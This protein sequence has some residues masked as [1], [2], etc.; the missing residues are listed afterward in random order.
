MDAWICRALQVLVRVCAS[1]SVD[2]CE[3]VH[4]NSVRQSSRYKFCDKT[5]DKPHSLI[6]TLQESAARTYVGLLHHCRRA[7]VSV[8]HLVPDQV[9][10][11]I[12][13]NIYDGGGGKWWLDVVHLR[14]T[15][16][17]GLGARCSRVRV[18]INLGPKTPP[19]A[20]ESFL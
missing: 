16:Q 9:R 11:N 10:V 7:G 3:D 2:G 4:T 14:A 17:I 8:D 1:G 18:N 6:I 15:V 13:Q 5:T 19:A 12:N 20:Q